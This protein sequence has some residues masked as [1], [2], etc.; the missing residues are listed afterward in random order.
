MIFGAT[1]KIVSVSHVSATPRGD[2]GDALDDGGAW[3]D[4]RGACVRSDGALAAERGTVSVV[5]LW[6]YLN[7][8]LF[9]V[10]VV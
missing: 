9:C 6:L 10:G 7:V 1:G 2:D 4:A 5:A 8:S 3:D